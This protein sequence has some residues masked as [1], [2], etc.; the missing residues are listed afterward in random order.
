MDYSM[1]N[2]FEPSEQFALV[3]EVLEQIENY[4]EQKSLAE[5]RAWDIELRKEYDLPITDSVIPRED[6]PER[7]WVG[8]P[9][10]GVIKRFIMRNGL[11][12][13]RT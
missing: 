1:N 7:G 10:L 11:A 12:I 3:D 2:L 13:S 6:I 5:L 8:S 4:M 9:C